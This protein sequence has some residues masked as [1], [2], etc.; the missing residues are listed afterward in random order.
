M[1]SAGLLVHVVLYTSAT[2][3][4]S[5]FSSIK[6]ATPVSVN[7][8]LLSFILLTASGWSRF[9]GLHSYMLQLTLLE[10]VWCVWQVGNK[11]WTD[12]KMCNDKWWMITVNGKWSGTAALPTLVCDIMSH[13]HTYVMLFFFFKFHH[14]LFFFFF[15]IDCN[16]VTW[17]LVNLLTLPC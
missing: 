1:A 4:I 10:D 3:G 7:S 11:T 16:G 12:P 13:N 6:D 9:S 14:D 15:L 17:V 8:F 2:V 5:T